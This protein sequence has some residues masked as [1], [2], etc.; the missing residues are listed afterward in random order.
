M[1]KEQQELSAE[2]Q[3]WVTE[4]ALEGAS[5]AQLVDALV[6]EGI[7]HEFALSEISRL[8]NSG[9]FRAAF[10]WRRQALRYKKVNALKIALHRW[11][12]PPIIERRRQLN[13]KALRKHYL[14]A[15]QPVILTDIIDQWPA[16]SKWT[17]EYLK[18]QVGHIMMTCCKGR[19]KL[20]NP[21]HNIKRF[22]HTMSFADFISEL[23][24]LRES[25]DLYLVG[26]NKFLEHEGA[27]IL[28]KDLD[29][30]I[31]SFLHQGIKGSLA[32][33]WYGPKGTITNLHYDP[34]S[35][36][37]AQVRG[38]KRFR[39]LSPNNTV[40]LFKAEHTYSDIDLEDAAERMGDQVYE[41]ILEPGELL[42]LPAGWWHEVTA[43]ET[44]ISIGFTNLIGATSFSWYTP[45]Q[46]GNEGRE[47]LK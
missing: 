23:Q 10:K 41:L 11:H 15:C 1:R 31:A 43:L 34:T 36:L 47:L 39:L 17:D 7:Q 44:S 28:L 19:E 46:A 27:E 8:I 42:L 12:G 25:N 5:L 40:A 24:K 22:F 30:R 9:P 35:V 20:A 45:G 26:N 33:F 3:D 6:E 4:N 37:Y 16:L 13:S 14:R 18:K 32:S 29:D 2:W 38:K 21:C